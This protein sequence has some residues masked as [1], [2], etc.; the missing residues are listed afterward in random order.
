[1]PTDF[2]P[3]SRLVN[4][5][6]VLDPIAEEGQRRALIPALHHPQVF[7]GGWGGGPAGYAE[8]TEDFVEFLRGYLPPTGREGVG[9]VVSRSG[10]V[11]GTSSFLNLDLEHQA[12]PSVEIGCTAYA[13]TMW[14][15]G[16]NA[17]VKL[18]MLTHA[19]DSGF[20]RV[21]FNVDGANERS[22]RAVARLGATQE[23]V[24]PRHRQR[25]DGSW[26]DTVV[27][28]I[29]RADWPRVAAGLRHR[30]HPAAP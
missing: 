26:R 2:P 16:I 23:S 5:P 3:Q 21:V 1:M 14:G 6:V 9:Y 22:L 24:I 25:A 12:G 11:A 18:L 17:A 4:D 30:L 27:H 19:F 15:D 10:S 7:A 28:S 20:E 13:P 29:I 8:D